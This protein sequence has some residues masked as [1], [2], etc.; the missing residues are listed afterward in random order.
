M[1]ATNK[2]N[3][4]FF[5][6]VWKRLHI[7]ATC[8]KGLQRVID[9]A[10]HR[11]NI[12]VL[13][14][15]SEEEHQA[16]AKRHG[17]NT[18]YVDNFPVG[19]KFNRGMEHALTLGWDYLFQINSDTLISN[20]LFDIFLSAMNADEGFV[21]I[22]DLVI[23]NTLTGEAKTYRYTTNGCG[24][25]AIRRDWIE[26]VGYMLYCR[27]KKTRSGAWIAYRAGENRYL[28]VP[29]TNKPFVDALSEKRVFRL[30]P[31]DAN[32]RLDNSSRDTFFSVYGE[33]ALW[34]KTS[35]QPLVV[36]MKSETNIWS[37]EDLGDGVVLSDEEKAGLKNYF[38]EIEEVFSYAPAAGDENTEG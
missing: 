33:P 11:A 32:K 27:V 6:P 22:E 7:T 38:P 8:Y 19:S 34:I 9:Y 31:P 18:F 28:P 36:D 14:V 29:L 26:N 24:I 13:I 4:L 2:L 23:Y 3:I 12:S 5:I 10:G 37:Y 35:V 30:W 21:S 1:E 17:F 25:R 20:K 16:L 15:C